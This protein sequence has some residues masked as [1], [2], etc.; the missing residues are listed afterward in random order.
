MF[1]GVSLMR[2]MATWYRRNLITSIWRVLLKDDKEPGSDETNNLSIEE[3]VE[4]SV[5]GVR[6]VVIKGLG[7][8]LQNDIHWK[9][10]AGQGLGFM[11]QL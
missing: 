9:E 2:Q 10:C 6:F 11:D 7:H 4:S 1:I 5:N 3:G 8:Q